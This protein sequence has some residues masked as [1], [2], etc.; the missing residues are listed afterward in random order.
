MQNSGANLA[1]R[2]CLALSYIDSVTAQHSISGRRPNF[3]ALSRGVTYIRRAASA[4]ILVLYGRP[5]QQMRTYFHGVVSSS[6]L[7]SRL[8]SAVGD[9][10]SIILP[11]IVEI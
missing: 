2:P 4:H 5:A 10:M 8:I 3:P 1:L 9:W 6:F 7:F 11:H